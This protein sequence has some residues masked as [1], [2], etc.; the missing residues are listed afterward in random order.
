VKRLL[1]ARHGE[2]GSNVAG[3]V[4]GVP[5]GAELTAAGREQAQ[6]LERQLAGDRLDLGVST[7][8]TRTQETLAIALAGR[9]VKRIVVPELNEI[10]FGAFDGGSLEA[11][12]NWAW[13]EEPDVHPPGDGESRAEVAARVADGLD[14]L[15]ARDEETIL[16]VS[17]ALPVRYILDAADGMF[18]AARIEHVEHGL[19]YPLEAAAL[20]RAAETLRVWSDEPAFR[21]FA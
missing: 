2:A 6:A 17:H 4:S 1:L 13:T 16:A 20:A 11:Y 5:P 12:R 10:R 3:T 19:V 15:L 7:E 21:D 9:D 8:F 14:L 18:P